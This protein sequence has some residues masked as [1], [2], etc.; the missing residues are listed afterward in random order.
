MRRPR[1][2]VRKSLG[3]LL[4]RGR[5]TKPGRLGTER[6]EERALLAV[7]AVLSD[8]NLFISSTAAGDML[9]EIVSDGTTYTVSGTGL[10]ATQFPIAS[11]TGRIFVGGGAGG[12]D[13]FCVLAGEPLANPIGVSS[14]VETTELR[15]GINATVAGNVNIESLSLII[16]LESPVLVSTSATNSNVT[17]TA[18]TTLGYDASFMSGSGF[19]SLGSVSGAGGQRLELG[20]LN[21]SGSVMING[22]VS[23]PSGT[24]FTAAAAFGLSLEGDANSILHTEFNN[25]GSLRIGNAGGTSTFSGGLS[26]TRASGVSLA[27]VVETVDTPLALGYVSL[28][29]DATLRSGSGAITTG[30]VTDG[31]SSRT[32][33]LGS[34]TQTGAITL[35]G[36]VTIDGLA[37]AAGN[38]TV[39]LLGS[40]NAIDQQVA[41]TNTQSVVFGDDTNDVSLFVGGVTATSQTTGSYLIGMVQT[42]G[43]SIDVGGAYLA[44]AT[45]LDT[46]NAGAVAGGASIRLRNGVSLA[47]HVLTTIGGVGASPAGTYLLGTGGFGGG[48]SGPGSLVVE[49]G[50]L[51]IGDG[52]TK[53]A[54]L[55]VPNNTTI[56]VT[57]GTLTVGTGSTIDATG[58]T[59]TL[60]AD[61]IMIASAAGSIDAGRITLA[62][63]TAGRDIF[64]GTAT[65]TGLVLDTAEIQAIDADTIQ[66]GKTGYT[67][68]VTLGTLAL[69][70]TTLAIVADGTGGGVTLD[71]PFTATGS[72]PGGMGLEIT[73]SGAGTVLNGNITSTGYVFIDDAVELAANVTID[74]SA[75]GGDVYITG[76][77]TGIWS[78]K[79]EANDLVARAGS[80]SVILASLASLND[81]WGAADLVRNVTLTGGS[82]LL[83]GGNVISGGLSLGAPQVSLGAV[84]RAAGPISIDDGAGGDAAVVILSNTILDATQ[85]GKVSAGNAVTIRGTVTALEANNSFFSLKAGTDGDVLVTGRMG[86][87][88]S[89]AALGAVTITGNDL[90]VAAID[91]LTAGLFLEG[92]DAVGSVDPGSVTLTGTTYQTDTSLAISAGSR[93][94]APDYAL[95]SPENRITLAGG[96]AGATTSFVTS[97]FD[98]EFSGNVDLAGRNL[99]V[100]TTNGGTA[101][102]SGLIW[103]YDAV[104]GAGTLTLN[105]GTGGNILVNHLTGA[106]GSTT[107]LVGVTVTNGNAVGFFGD[108]S[109]GVVRIVDATAAVTFAGVLDITGGFVTEAQPY[110]VQM[111]SGSGGSSR[112]AGVTTFGNTGLLGLGNQG[113]S[114]S[115][116][117]TGGVVA[118]APSEV[119]LLASVLADSGSILLGDADTDVTVLSGTVGG[120]ATAITL[121]DVVLDQNGQLILG[122]G[123][124]NTIQVGSVTGTVTGFA[125]A[126]SINTTGTVT[127]TG[128]V[129]SGLDRLTVTKSGGTT[130]A[131]VVAAG[132]V[133]LT[134]TTGTITFQ[135]NVTATTLETA[136]NGYSVAFQ[137]AA[138]T[139]AEN[140]SFLNTGWVWFGNDAG[141]ESTFT[142]GLSTSG[143]PI[144][145]VLSGTLASSGNVSLGVATLVTN[146]SFQG[147]LITFG[148]TLHGGSFGLTTSDPFSLDGGDAEF[149]GA[150]TAGFLSIFGTTTIAGPSVTTGGTQTYTQQV[151]ITAPSVVLRG[152]GGMA[153]RIATVAGSNVELDFDDG[154]TL[155]QTTP[156][157]SLIVGTLRVSD[158]VLFGSAIVGSLALTPAATFQVNLPL[159]PDGWGQIQVAGSSSATVNLGSAA[160]SLTG[161]AP[162]PLGTTLR[163]IDNYSSTAPVTGTFAGLPEGALFDSPLGVCRISYAGGDGNDVTVEAVSRDNVVSLEDGYL[164]MNLA[165]TGT[166]VRNLS[167]QYRAASRQLVIT[168]LTDRQLTGG[169]TG[170]TVNPRAGTVTV[171]LAQVPTFRGI[172]VAGTGATDRITLG[173]RGV[174]LATLTAGDASQAFVI[175]TGLGADVVTVRSPVSTKGTDGGFIVEAATINVGT[176]ISTGFGQQR[177]RGHVT[178]VGDTSLTG[179]EIRFDTK[180]DGA[181]R[182]TLNASGRVSFDDS[183]GGLTP[184]KGIAIQ[185]ATSFVA[186]MGLRLD[187]RG[188]GSTANGLVIGRGVGSVAIGTE[189]PGA[190]PVTISNFGGSGILFQ[191]GSQGSIIGRAT[192]AGNGQG[193]TLLPGDYTGTTVVSNAILRS[194]RAAIMLDGARN[195]WI[196]DDVFSSENLIQGGAV[197]RLSGKGIVAK[198]LLTGTR[199]IGNTIERNNGGIVLQDA[200]GLTVGG[201]ALIGGAARTNTIISNAAWGLI[202]SGDCTGSVIDA[203]TISGNTPGDVN[204]LRARGIVVVPPG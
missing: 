193:I 167:T 96:V 144:N 1:R 58:K 48:S 127:I 194:K 142:G 170:L 92:V 182:L 91:G 177:Y 84:V 50:S 2:R 7:T 81:N 13:K 24:M 124:A 123:L 70:D 203:N 169:G 202:G 27:G 165:G 137:G 160:L 107:P 35:G 3:Q 166:T 77:S 189:D 139:V 143:G 89:G 183:I 204:V 10:S 122:T 95:G 99:S 163:I 55:T 176:A 184:L 197:A 62:P 103:I 63:V 44:G 132:T 164:I 148:G 69:A 155:P 59:L 72:V 198:G 19:I 42:A 66:I 12:G 118:T 135:G 43:G 186:T 126:F 157:F 110:A 133:T 178:L 47:G 6:L 114:D 86:V 90:T 5:G 145:T 56:E 80:G 93:G 181:R 61:D 14:N 149:G 150:V 141:D 11:V 20:D 104:D 98:V 36:S 171:S 172:I 75:G 190:R 18:A 156:P 78:S 100:D 29:A 51:F 161:S 97:G 74:T 101:T 115:I 73:G 120:A 54:A 21:Q 105:A 117:F 129:G 180:V 102:R 31:V 28:L 17:I 32:L 83:G 23:L 49:S 85:E 68:R 22:N 192:L 173:P 147:P 195:V 26:A 125:D 174:N 153:S 41:F 15:A 138:T 113:A 9:A 82:V 121:A 94:P 175:K 71:G 179:G 108:L 40:S 140:T 146:V 88:G 201:T 134:D 131:A 158:G 185:R 53:V 60:L 30:A 111:D 57:A 151:T 64:L 76:G 200:K 25:T 38:F 87:V 39:S 8:G 112:I 106:V 16:G 116:T 154:F 128:S 4:G 119:R 162:L 130:F 199:I 46:S 37:T 159:G 187:G 109:A 136:A 67:G 45:T 168:A 33:T 65:G 34:P 196:G 79:G 188:A 152:A 52:P 191:G